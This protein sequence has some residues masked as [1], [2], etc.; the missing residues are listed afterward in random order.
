MNGYQVQN[1]GNLAIL[2]KNNNNRMSAIIRNM[3]ESV[4]SKTE[5]SNMNESVADPKECV[6]PNCGTRFLVSEK[7]EDG[8][9]VFCPTCNFQVNTQAYNN[10]LVDEESELVESLENTLEKYANLVESEQ[11]EE[12][13]LLLESED[14]VAISDEEGVMLEKVKI[15]VHADGKKEKKKIKTKKKKLKGKRLAAAKKNAKKMAKSAGAKKKRAKAMKARRKKVKNEMMETYAVTESIMNVLGTHGIS[16]IDRSSVTRLLRENQIRM[17]ESVVDEEDQIIGTIENALNNRGIEVLDTDVESDEDGV[18]AVELL[19]RDTESEIYLG[20]VSDEIAKTCN[21]QV[22]YD[23]PE[24]DEEDESLVDLTFYVISNV[25][26]SESTES[27][28]D[29]SDL[30]GSENESCEKKN[31]CSNTND[32]ENENCNKSKNESVMVG[33]ITLNESLTY[34]AGG[35]DNVRCKLNPAFIR[36]GQLIYDADSK[37]VFKSLTE[38]VHS[39]T[40]YKLTIDILNSYDSNLSGVA[41]ADVDITADGNY[42]LLKSNPFE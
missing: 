42:F 39:G 22:E 1:M 34:Y 14:V 38:S 8:S 23:D 10:S 13:K 20:E 40:D 37:T 7:S 24:P 26:L 28:T 30:E 35:I 27:S 21:C 4:A 19:V 33:G 15:I 29:D 36:P 9:Q 12:A 6:C 32:K 25:Q 41:G 3:N 2:G 16:N 31:E 11:Y 17:N 18:L 5:N